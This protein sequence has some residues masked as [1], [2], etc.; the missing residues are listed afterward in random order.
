MALKV[1]GTITDIKDA[2]AITDK[3]TK[4]ELILEIPDDKYP[5]FCS[6]EFSNR[7]CEALD[8]F[9]IG[10]EVE[11]T[12]S[13]RGREYKGKHYNSLAAYKIEQTGT[14]VK[15]VEKV[16]NSIRE[17]VEDFNSPDDLPF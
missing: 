8:Q 17:A 4:R 14:Q 1:I 5:Q 3:F 12:F 11:L 15:V 7:G 9:K 10:Q 2:Q 16:V 13:L 6:F